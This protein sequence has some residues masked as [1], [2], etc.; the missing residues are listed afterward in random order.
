M[1]DK[2]TKIEKLAISGKKVFTTQD[3]AAIWQIPERRRLIE[4]VKYYLRE[5]RLTPI[6]K[7]I[8]AYGTDYTP[9]DI[10]QKLMPLSYI[11]LYTTSQMYGLTFQ[12]YETI[13]ALALKSKKYTLGKQSYIYH[14]IKE[15]IFYKQ[16]GLVNNGRYI[17]ADKERTIT[18]CLYVFPGFA[19]DNLHG[20]DKE[21]LVKLAEIYN[22]KRLTKEV[23]KLLDLID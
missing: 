4:L 1:E 11:S 23:T 15:S 5:K 13:Y 9:L 7:G 10:A 2:T 14:R 17:I 16:M 8:Y 21:K 6:H 18:D 19:F 3:L 20:V 22:N 12:Y